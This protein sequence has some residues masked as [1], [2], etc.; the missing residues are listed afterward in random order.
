MSETYIPTHDGSHGANLTGYPGMPQQRAYDQPPMPGPTGDYH[1]NGYGGASS[2]G[3]PQPPQPGGHSAG[4]LPGKILAVLAVAVLLVL[5][6]GGYALM[7]HGK[8]G[9][10]ET[11]SDGLSQ[12]LKKANE[13]IAAKQSEL[14]STQ[15]E[16]EAAQAQGE[17][18]GLALDVA[19]SCATQ[20]DAGWDLLMTS[21]DT[22]QV[23]AAYEASREACDQLDAAQ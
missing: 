14:D 17:Q 2:Y 22:D 20:L 18:V 3:P 15:E 16:L 5:A 10:A 8:L 9:D 6:L 4:R 11:K 21:S 13:S 7:S 1:S 23:I 12:S 19:M